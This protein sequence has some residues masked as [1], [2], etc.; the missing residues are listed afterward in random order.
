M[1][2]R[3]ISALLSHYIKTKQM[4]VV[5]MTLTINEK[6]LDMNENQKKIFLW[7]EMLHDQ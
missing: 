3:K 2:L 7:T 5:M 6:I 4:R 1:R